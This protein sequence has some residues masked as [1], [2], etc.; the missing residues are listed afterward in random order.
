MQIHDGKTKASRDVIQGSIKSDK[1][2]WNKQ[3][4]R[5]KDLQKHLLII[6][7]LSTQF[8]NCGQLV[9]ALD[10]F[11]SKAKEEYCS[12][13][14]DKFHEV[15]SKKVSPEQKKAVEAAIHTLFGTDKNIEISPD[16]LGKNISSKYGEEDHTDTEDPTDTFQDDLLNLIGEDYPLIFILTKIQVE[17]H[18]NITVLISIVTDIA[19][20]N[21]KVYPQAA[22]IISLFLKFEDDPHQKQLL[23]QKI[24]KKFNDISNTGE[25]DIWIQRITLAIKRSYPEVEALEFQEKLCKKV[26]QA[27][28]SIWDF[29]WVRN[30]LAKELSEIPITDQA[31]IDKLSEIIQ[32]DE[33]ALFSYN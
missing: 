31:K 17:H 3:K 25:L 22:A 13:W 2:F 11:Y 8:P 16:F 26:T 19:H 9:K 32:K 20:K 24:V 6:H 15:L 28:T 33:I 5:E 29:S 14:V 7:D 10:D 4:Q 23:L 12:K 30:D 21:P 27:E 18:E 1:W